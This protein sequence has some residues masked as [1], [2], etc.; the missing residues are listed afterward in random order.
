MDQE[1]PRGKN[2]LLFALSPEVHQRLKPYLQT[3]RLERQQLLYSPGELVT[4]AFFPNGGVI[5]IVAAMEDGDTVEVALVGSEGFI[6]VGAVLGDSH[7][8]HQ[9]IVQTET[10]ATRLPMEQVK[11][12]FDRGGE[13]QRLS[14]RYAQARMLLIAQGSACN[15][16]HTI[17]ERLARRLLLMQDRVGS[18]QLMLTQE[19]MAEML[20]TRRSGLAVAIGTLQ[21][22]GIIASRRGMVTIRDRE[23]LEAVSCECYRMIKSHFQRLLG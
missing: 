8:N 17:E 12:E 18:N 4:D 3:V 10:T 1:L 20:G 15:R 6:G 21:Q 9:V 2:Q 13:L 19:F 11:A 7:I 14:L 22:A 5:S 23:A 16:L